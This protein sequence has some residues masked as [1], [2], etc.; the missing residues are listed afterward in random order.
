MRSIRTRA[1]AMRAECLQRLTEVAEEEEAQRVAAAEA[2]AAA[3][4]K[5]TTPSGSLRSSSLK[6]KRLFARARTKINLARK[7]QNDTLAGRD[8]LPIVLNGSPTSRRALSEVPSRASPHAPRTPRLPGVPGGGADGGQQPGRISLGDSQHGPLAAAPGAEL[9]VAL[10]QLVE[11][12]TPP[13][14]PVEGPSGVAQ[15]RPSGR[16]RVSQAIANKAP[17]KMHGR[18]T[19]DAVVPH[20]PTV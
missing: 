9:G 13:R 20:P 5:S 8:T 2:A 15:R 6:S 14:R 19:F 18:V 17:V 11:P 16:G 10:P 3:L 7:A 4:E 1:N 12:T